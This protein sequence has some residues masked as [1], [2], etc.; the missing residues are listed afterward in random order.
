[1]C[2]EAGVA[3]AQGEIPVLYLDGH[4]HTTGP[5][6]LEGRFHEGLAVRV[7]AEGSQNFCIGRLAA[8]PQIINGVVSNDLDCRANASD[9]KGS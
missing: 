7:L 5:S 9:R 2:D 8:L 6:V 3:A 4:G 1:M